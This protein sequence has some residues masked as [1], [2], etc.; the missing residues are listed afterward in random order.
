MKNILCIWFFFGIIFS[1]FAQRFYSDVSNLKPNVG[2]PFEY[3]ITIENARFSGLSVPDFGPFQ[4][5]GKTNNKYNFNGVRTES[6]SFTLIPTQQGVY[7][8]PSSSATINGVVMHTKPITIKV[9]KGNTA[10]ENSNSTKN[11][12]YIAL[13]IE[14]SKSFAY[15]GE[16]IEISYV[17]YANTLGKYSFIEQYLPPPTNALLKEKIEYSK[18]DFKPATYKGKNVSKLELIKIIVQPT[19]V[20]FLTVPAGAITVELDRNEGNRAPQNPFDAF[21]G[22]F[23]DNNIFRK[24]I[25]AQALKIPVKSLP[26]SNVPTGFKGAIGSYGIEASVYDTNAVEGESFTYKLLLSGA[27]NIN[28][29]PS[30]LIDSDNNWDVFT[31]QIKSD[32][33]DSTGI[34]LGK[35]EYSYSFIPKKSGNLIIPAQKFVFFNPTSGLYEVLHTKEISMHVKENVTLVSESNNSIQN[36]KE[37]PGIRWTEILLAFISIVFSVGAGLGVWQLLK[38]VKKQKTS[39]SP[40]KMLKELEPI[41]LLKGNDKYVAW[42]KWL[43]LL[44][45]QKYAID[46]YYSQLDK[47]TYLL[48]KAVPDEHIQVI[49]RI[50]EHCQAAR[51]APMSELH[52]SELYN[53][54][55]KLV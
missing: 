44:L 45:K 31:P 8:I 12:P 9:G 38:Y 26:N 5:I 47:K 34:P 50:F 2:E 42:E 51:Y 18:R 49:I 41:Q 1:S 37:R 52:E 6:I 4:I 33:D 20:G 27:G 55:K 3:V 36:F 13:A 16:P 24:N 30:Y 35:I 53:L 11:E 21:F 43:L 29:L 22:G 17:L 23:M 25:K 15:L 40:T 28:L 7:K 39:Y 48:S 32:I 46:E 10:F 14:S 19:Q 54:S